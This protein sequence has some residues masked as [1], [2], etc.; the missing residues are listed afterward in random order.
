MVNTRNFDESSTLL[1]RLPAIPEKSGRD[2]AAE[3][4]GNREAEE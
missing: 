3:A 2:A 1:Q 4:G